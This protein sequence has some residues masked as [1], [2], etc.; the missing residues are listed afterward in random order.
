ME[1]QISKWLKK[2]ERESWQLELLVSGFTIFLLIGAYDELV[3][4]TRDFRFNNE[5]GSG[6]Y[7]AAIMMLY[8]ITKC[9]MV[10]TFNLIMHLILRGFWIGA[11]GLRSVGPSIDYQRLKYHEFYID[12]LKRKMSSMDHLIVGLDRLCSVI[13]SFSFLSFLFSL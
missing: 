13:F 11:I 2:L 10:L 9:T 12:K 4:F 8:T 7:L 6:F 1:Q 3:E 5:G